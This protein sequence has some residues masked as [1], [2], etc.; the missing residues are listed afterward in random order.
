[1]REPRGGGQPRGVESQEGIKSQEG[2]ESQGRKARKSGEPG[3]GR[4]ARGVEECLAWSTGGYRPWIFAN[5][6]TSLS[7]PSIIPCPT[8]LVMLGMPL[9]ALACERGVATSGAILVEQES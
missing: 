2:V 9:T 8:S 4:E 3:G 6:N 7:T 5:S 1:M